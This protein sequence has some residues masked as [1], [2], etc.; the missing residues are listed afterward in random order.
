MESLN[1][2]IKE[3]I[4]NNAVDMVTFLE[5]VIEKYLL[6]NCKSWSKE[7]MEL[8]NMAWLKSCQVIKLILP[9]GFR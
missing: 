8:E 3:Q 9:D 5:A 6:N 4:N 2:V 1:L 7:S